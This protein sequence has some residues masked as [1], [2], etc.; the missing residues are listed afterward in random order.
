MDAH[1]AAV[2]SNVCV[3]DP[4]GSSGLSERDA[5]DMQAALD[6]VMR[7]KQASMVHYH[8]SHPPVSM[9]SYEHGICSRE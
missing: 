5:L 6:V 8:L 7:Q 9:E 2:C 1:V 3:T 4:P